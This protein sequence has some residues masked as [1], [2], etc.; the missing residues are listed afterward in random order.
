MVQ[1][2]EVLDVYLQTKRDSAAVKR[3]FRRSLKH[4]GEEPRKNVKDKLWSYVVAHRELI[5]G[6]LHSN[7]ESENNSGKKSHKSTKM[8]ERVLCGNLSLLLKPNDF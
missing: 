6:T 1:D 3:F 8:R 4:H 2:G 5:P 7:N